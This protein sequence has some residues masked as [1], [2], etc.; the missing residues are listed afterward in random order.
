MH[1]PNN[2]KSARSKYFFSIEPETE[3]KNVI[4]NINEDIVEAAYNGK[5]FV[6]EPQINCDT[7]SNL[8]ESVLEALREAKF[9]VAETKEY[10]IIGWTDDPQEFDKIVESEVITWHLVTHGL[11]R[12]IQS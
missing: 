10:I 2:A 6:V 11:N 7:E 3:L 5:L 9:H 4:A 8:K 1:F 12:I